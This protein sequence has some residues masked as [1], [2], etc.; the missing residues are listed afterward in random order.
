MGFGSPVGITLGMTRAQVR[1][2]HAAAE[3]FIPNNVVPFTAYYCALGISVGYADS[4]DGSGNLANTLSDD[5][6]VVRVS[7]LAGFQGNTDTGLHVGSSEG[8]LQTAYGSTGLAQVSENLLGGSQDLYV[9]RGLAFGLDAGG[10]VS[11]MAVHKPYVGTIANSTA[12]APVSL[13]DLK[14]GALQVPT[15]PLLTTG[16]T[17]F[18]GVKTLLGQPDTQGFANAGGQ[19][20]AYLSYGSAG[21]RVVGLKGSASAIDDVKTLQV[22]LTP[23]FVGIDGSTGLGLGSTRTGWDSS[24]FENLGVTNFNGVDLTKYKVGSGTLSDKVVAVAFA[25]DAQCVD[26]AALMVFNYFQ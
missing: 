23:P 24:G 3:A 8:D 14:V 7:T 9:A 2:A 13:G 6:V 25:Q 26:H 22:Y 10:N 18:G 19:E 5:D 20:I 1:A 11:W 15:G 4:P 16:A 21:V 17:V 12:N